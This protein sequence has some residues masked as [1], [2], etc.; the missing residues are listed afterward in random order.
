[1]K[2]ITLKLSIV[3]MIL[4]STL[5]LIN[6]CKNKFDDINVF[7]AKINQSNFFNSLTLNDQIGLTLLYQDSTN[8]IYTN[9]R[10]FL[11]NLNLSYD[12]SDLPFGLALFYDD[13][14]DTTNFNNLNCVV[15]YYNNSQNR[16]KV[17]LKE[18]GNFVL[19]QNYSKISHFIA[20]EDFYRLDIAKNLNSENVLLLLNQVVLPTNPYYSEFQTVVDIEYASLINPNSENTPDYIRMCSNNPDCV[21]YPWQGT[22]FWSEHQTGGTS[23]HCNT[24]GTP[25]GECV[26]EKASIIL[27]NNNTPLDSGFLAKNYKIRDSVLL[28]DNK[29]NFLIDDYYYVSSIIA[30]ELTLSIALDIYNLNNTNFLDI[31]KNYNNSNY[32]DSILITH[33]S[34]PIL[35]SI[36]NKSKN[37]TSD[38][39]VE[40]I[41]NNLI[42]KINNYDNKTITYIKNN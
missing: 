3:F 36:C 35:L 7:D 40:T 5:I 6:S 8:N 13:E 12:Y 14:I 11:D 25:D 4:L 29:L 15:Y 27:Y 34:K 21:L 38:S 28:N 16:V 32:S 37:L 22:C 18:S 41:F 24:L 26:Q 9:I 31:L 20:N 19:E 17:W 1:M 2:N 42:S 39:K 23:S 33:Q 30:T 10:H